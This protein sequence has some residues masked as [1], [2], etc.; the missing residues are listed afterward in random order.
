[1][2]S[3]SGFALFGP[4]EADATATLVANSMRTI[5]ASPPFDGTLT[6]TVIPATP[7]DC[8]DAS[9]QEEGG[10]HTMN[11]I[12]AG[13]GTLCRNVNGQK[14]HPPAYMQFPFI[15]TGV[16]VVVARGPR[17]GR[18]NLSI[19]GG[20]PTT[21]DLYRP[22]TDPAHPDM[23]GRRDLDLGVVVHVDVPS[24]AHTLRVDVLNDSGVDTRNMIYID[25]FAIYG[26]DASGTPA[27]TTNTSSMLNGV[28]GGLLGTEYTLF[29][30]ANTVN[31]DVILAAT[32]GVTVRVKDPAGNV[33]ASGTNQNG[34]I[35]IQFGP[36]GIG[37][38]TID[39]GN[40]TAGQVDFDVWEV[41]ESR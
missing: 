39:L 7:V 10:W 13:N 2:Y 17:G 29:S 23:S 36:N 9:V 18:F 27:T 19:D 35:A 20:T 38:Y 11:D 25:G 24:G 4:S 6:P 30:T 5:D 15:G 33:V 34:V 37:A 32:P 1:V 26:G 8:T 22:P 31:M 28:L 21:V 14:T 12:G 16:D 41:V 3:V 40:P